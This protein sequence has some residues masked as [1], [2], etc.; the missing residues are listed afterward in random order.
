[1]NNEQYKE[2]AGFGI[3]RSELRTAVEARLAERIENLKE[4]LPGHEF[5]G[6][7]WSDEYIDGYIAATEAE[8]AFL[9][10]VLNV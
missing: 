4:T 6:C 3:N 8:I 10:G 1:M 2:L 7:G 5:L 9:E